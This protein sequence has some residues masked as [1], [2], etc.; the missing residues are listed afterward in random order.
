MPQAKDE[1]TARAQDPNAPLETLHQLAQNYPDLRPHI[2]ANP[3]TYPALLEWLGTLDDPAV[4]AALAAR[5]SG[6]A[7]GAVTASTQVL[8]Q[9]PSPQAAPTG[10]AYRAAGPTEAAS[11]VSSVSSASPAAT[12]PVTAG[13]PA[14]HTIARTVGSTGVAGGQGSPSGAPSSGV[15]PGAPAQASGPAASPDPGLQA[16]QAIP[17]QPPSDPQATRPQPVPRSP[18]QVS[19]AVSQTSAFSTASPQQPSPYPA[20]QQ[21]APAYSPASPVPA[22]PLAHVP[23]QPGAEAPTQAVAAS[24][25]HPAAPGTGAPAAVGQPGQSYQP[26][27]PRQPRRAAAAVGHATTSARPGGTPGTKAAEAT[28]FGV[29]TAEAEETAS[30]SPSGR[31]LW[32]LATVVAALLVFVMT[33][34]LTGGE[35]ESPTNAQGSQPTVAAQQATQAAPSASPSATPS[36]SPTPSATPSLDLSAPAPDDAL[37]MS[38]FTTPSGN[39]SCSLGED[40]VSCTINDHDFVG[41]DSSCS[42]SSEPFTASVGVEGG[43]SGSCE[44][45]FA[46]TGASLQYGASA[47]NDTFACTSSEEGIECW[48]QVTGQGFTLSRASSE[49]TQR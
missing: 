8:P 45:D 36:A 33:W 40:S 26:T 11:S 24:S 4:D 3:R 5:A 6:M 20:G 1:L 12:S 15:L 38:V 13:G 23:T 14:G 31:F 34:V 37:E 46:S 48:S 43:A 32:I 39:I 10:S 22:A 44:E 29:G 18:Y 17:S 7:G 21:P 49:T 19:P 27:P 35:D 41:E 16:T 30:D 47:K 42:G 25:A 2:A 28:V 9:S